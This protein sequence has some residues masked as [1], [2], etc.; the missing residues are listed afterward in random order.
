V[1]ALSF[2]EARRLFEPPRSEP[3][4]LHHGVL[5]SGQR[6]AGTHRRTRPP[7]TGLGEITHTQQL[8]WFRSNA[9]PD[10]RPVQAIP[11]VT[12]GAQ[13]DSTT[14]QRCYVGGRVRARILQTIRTRI[15]RRQTLYQGDQTPC[16]SRSSTEAVTE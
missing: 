3:L 12:H 6:S 9:N 14:L 10:H 11:E 4:A 1:L 15:L 13:S 5:I 7:P 8:R 2:A 16:A